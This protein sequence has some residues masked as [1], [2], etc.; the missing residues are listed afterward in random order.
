MDRRTVRASA[1]LSAPDGRADP[2]A[3]AVLRTHGDAR[4]ENLLVHADARDALPWLARTHAGRV[5]CAYLDPPY[6]TGRRFAEYDDPDDPDAFRALLE[7]VLDAAHGLLA[8]D[9][10]LFLQID[11]GR[12]GL[13]LALGDARFGEG[14]RVSVVTVVRSAATGHKARNVGPVNVTDYLL[15]WAKHRPRLAWPRLVRP[16]AGADRAYRTWVAERDAPAD[17]WTFEPLARVVARARGFASATAAA[18]AMGR[19]AFDAAVDAHALAHPRHVARFA[20]PRVEAIGKDAQAAVAR[21]KASP[22]RVLVHAR[23]GHPDLVLRG[24]NRVLFLDAKVGARD[25]GAPCLVE[26]LTN[27]WDDVPFQGLAGEGGVRFERNKKPERLLARVLE[28]ATGPGD[29]VLDPFAGSGTTPAVAHKLGRRWVAVERGD[30]L[31]TLAEPRLAR[32]V[33]GTDPT[34]VTRTSGHRGGGGFHVVA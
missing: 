33:A 10:S 24:G 9:G 18:R 25:D 15:V 27:V 14:A 4:D 8:E 19:E 1:P 17:A 11:D 20:Q 7:P 28:L 30:H 2:C 22:D 34:G 16:R 31:T 13:A 29:W 23:R 26:P 32:V 6:G 5:R 3:L 21:S 12:L